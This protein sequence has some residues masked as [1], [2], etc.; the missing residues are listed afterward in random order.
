MQQDIENIIREVKAGNKMAFKYLLDEHQQYAF[1]VAFRV[2]CNEEDAKD[3]VQESFIKIWKNIS[4][5]DLKLK[6]TSWMYKI[7]INSA[8]DKLRSIRRPNMVNIDTVS[9]NLCRL[10]RCG[11]DVQLENQELGNI[12]S[13]IAEGLPEKQKLVFVLRDIQGFD[14]IEVQNMLDMPATSVKSNLYNARQFVSKKLSKLP[15]YERRVR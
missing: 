14:S 15:A 7:V 8:L 1:R 10:E 13:H 11:P 2:L 4:N 12:I 3:V 6:F 5:F 9:E